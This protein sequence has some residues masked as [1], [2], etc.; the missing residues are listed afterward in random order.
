M[1][2]EQKL[3]RRWFQRDSRG[4]FADRRTLPLGT[5]LV[6]PWATGLNENNARSPTSALAMQFSVLSDLIAEN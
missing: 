3:S 6:T 2:A 1:I 5:S 4:S